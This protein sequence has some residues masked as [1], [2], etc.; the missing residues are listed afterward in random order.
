[1]APEWS[2]IRKLGNYPETGLWEVL[3]EGSGHIVGKQEVGNSDRIAARCPNWRL[4]V[5]AVAEFTVT[6]R[7]VRSIRAGICVSAAHSRE[8]GPI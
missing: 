2:A 8:L 4:V 6:A 3:P 7:E 1:M 5:S